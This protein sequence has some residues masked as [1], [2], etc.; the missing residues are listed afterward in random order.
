MIETVVG[1]CLFI[2]CVDSIRK[3]GCDLF[4]AIKKKFF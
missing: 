1:L 3:D 4:I 2:K